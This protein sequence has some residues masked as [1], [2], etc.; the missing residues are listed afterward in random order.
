MAASTTPSNVR[1]RQFKRRG[2]IEQGKVFIP[3]KLVITYRFKKFT[4]DAADGNLAPAPTLSAYGVIKNNAVGT[5]TPPTAYGEPSLLNRNAAA[6]ILYN[7]EDSITAATY[8]P[9][10]TTYKTLET[11][12]VIYF[13]NEYNITNFVAQVNGIEHISRVREVVL[14]VRPDEFSDE[15]EYKLV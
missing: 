15:V 13:D 12:Q 9:D 7:S 11:S 2:M 6:D 5:V 14:F 4:V 3:T 8:G 10:E 1:V